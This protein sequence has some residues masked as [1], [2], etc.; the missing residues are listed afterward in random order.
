MKGYSRTIRRWYANDCSERGITQVEL[1]IAVVLA[2][3]LL[4]AAFA[5]VQVA[6]SASARVSSQAHSAQTLALAANQIVDGSGG[7]F[8]GLRSASS[9]QNRSG[10]GFEFRY[11]GSSR[12]ESYW[13]SQGELLR[14]DDGGDA[15]AVARADSLSIENAGGSGFYTVRLSLN[16]GGGRTA[17]Y[18]TKV[19][20][21][22]RAK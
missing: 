9:V 7:V 17:E 22:N 2:A 13:I 10:G 5:Y 3:I 18:V 1:L 14:S 4:G 20:L 12:V 15:Q 8:R 11:S 21:R 6:M 16:T 19:R